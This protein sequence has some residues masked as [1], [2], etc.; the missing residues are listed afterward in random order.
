MAG[1]N[2]LN[3]LYLGLALG[4][5]CA[6]YAFFIG[7]AAWLFNWG[8]SI[9]EVVSSLYIGYKPTLIGSIVGSVWALIDGFIGGVIIAWLYNRF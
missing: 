5:S 3:V 6:I 2:H 7:A 1:R 9:V 4:I 8:T